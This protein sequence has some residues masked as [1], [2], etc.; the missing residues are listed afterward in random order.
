MSR[1]RE[2]DFTYRMINM[3]NLWGALTH[4]A[5]VEANP[6]TNPEDALE[7]LL[8]VADCNRILS[9]APYYPDAGEA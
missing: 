5:W 8:L 9:A 6:A 1:H 4:K 3:M 2:T 7:D